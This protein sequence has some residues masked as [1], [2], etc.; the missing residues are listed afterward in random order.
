V[1]GVIEV[2]VLLRRNRCAG[3]S[4]PGEGVVLVVLVGDQAERVRG[5]LLEDGAVLLRAVVGV[6]RHGERLLVAQ[7][8]LVVVLALAVQALLLLLGLDGGQLGQQL[9]NGLEVLRHCW[10]RRQL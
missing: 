7:L 6:V 8:L 4:V 1:A 3:A 10:W 5:L 9:V 2:A